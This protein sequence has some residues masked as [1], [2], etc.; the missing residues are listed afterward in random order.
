[1]GEEGGKGAK[2]MPRAVAGGK[3]KKENTTNLAKRVGP[4]VKQKKYGVNSERPSM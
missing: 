1:M 4:D 3:K 2:K